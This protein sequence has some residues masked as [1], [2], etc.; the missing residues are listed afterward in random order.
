MRRCFLP[1]ILIFYIGNAM[2][3]SS[4]EGSRDPKPGWSPSLA[5]TYLDSRAAWWQTWPKSQRDHETVCVSC[6]TVLPYAL[7]RSALSPALGE[8]SLPNS[9]RLIL[10][11][12]R[13]RVT[14]WKEVQP[15]YNDAKS[16]AG[17][18]V[19]SRATES[20]LNAL[21]LSSDERRRDHLSET[22]LA[23]FNAAW[24][25]Q[26]ASGPDAG[27]WNWQVFHL[28]PWESSQSQY[29][30][31]TFMALAVGYA[32]AHYQKDSKIEGN[33]KALRSYLTGHYATQPLL[34]RIVVLWA[35]ARLP[36]LL[37]RHER[38][39]LVSSIFDGQ[40]EDGG[41]SLSSLEPCDRSDHTPQ[42][43]T[44]DGYATGL[45]ILAIKEARV[46]HHQ[47][48]VSKGVS[49]L[50][51]NQDKVNGSWRAYSL[52]K[53]RDPATDVGKFMTDAATGYA[54]LA[55]EEHR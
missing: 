16:G 46:G 31:A 30:G 53:Q 23:A 9:Q 13:K 20:V 2:A 33:V 52:N 42:D 34:N 8:E 25:L 36:G 41:W 15:Y 39:E 18:S 44:S 40:N 47:L 3:A 24:A 28:A 26:L 55:L 48:Q 6:H 27:A 35:S 1:C 37:N 5:A 49:W 21:I 51:Q 22:A 32:P 10:A 19:E 17:K 11:G 29:Q 38:S 54:V 4:A 43:V 12:V 45:V 50:V 14:L 7:S